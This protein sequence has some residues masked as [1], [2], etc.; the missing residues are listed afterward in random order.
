MYFFNI[1]NE[2]KTN[3]DITTIWLDKKTHFYSKK[4]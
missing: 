4:Y 1:F 2:N 3:S